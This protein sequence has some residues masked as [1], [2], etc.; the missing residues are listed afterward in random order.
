M[1]HQ[2]TSWAIRLELPPALKLVLMCLA[3]YA[4]REGLDS[5]PG[6][7]KLEKDTGLSNRTIQKS[8]TVLCEQSLISC[9]NG[10]SGGRGN[11]SSYQLH[12]DISGPET[13]KFTTQNPEIGA[14]E[15]P[16]LVQQTP[17]L[18]QEN[19]EIHDIALIRI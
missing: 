17:K 19:P 16:K 1:S 14:T 4:N 6:M 3:H 11:R 10:R 9:L 8:L 5:Y 18:V 15:T 7:A 2:A 13:P 12:F